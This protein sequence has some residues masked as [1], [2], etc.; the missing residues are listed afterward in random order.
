[1]HCPTMCAGLISFFLIIHPLFPCFLHH[2]LSHR[3]CFYLL[4]MNIHPACT[5]HAR[6][7]ICAIMYAIHVLGGSIWCMLCDPHVTMFKMHRVL[8]RVLIYLL[9]GCSYLPSE[10]TGSPLQPITLPPSTTQNCSNTSQLIQTIS[11]NVYSIII[12]QVANN[13]SCV[14]N[15]T[16]IGWGPLCPA[17]SCKAIVAA[18]PNNPSG[19]YWI[20][21]NST[22]TSVQV[23]CDLIRY[24]NGSM[25]RLVESCLSEYVRLHTVLSVQLGDLHGRDL[26][27]VRKAR[28]QQLLRS[29][30][31]NLLG[32]LLQDQWV[33]LRLPV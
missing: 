19:Y 32:T 30:L 16:P 11:Q 24:L 31:H 6:I 8:C 27:F 25:Q 10:P 21:P 28:R 7:Y 15:G 33:D 2:Q 26:S 23:Y 13:L 12:Q 3:E 18:L 22:N 4:V 5:Y 1:M 9:L 14:L 17:S 29:E 20:L